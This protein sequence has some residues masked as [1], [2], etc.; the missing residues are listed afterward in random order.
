LVHRY[1]SGKFSKDTSATIGADFTPKKY[2]YNG[3]NYTCQ[4]WDTAGSERFKSLGAAFFRNCDCCV[5]VYDIT[6]K[7][8][9]TCLLIFLFITFITDILIDCLELQ[10]CIQLEKRVPGAG[11]SQGPSQFPFRSDRQQD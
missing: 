1:T 4:F 6:N 7:E 2:T 3:K 8:V 5:I 11:W 9:S 10:E